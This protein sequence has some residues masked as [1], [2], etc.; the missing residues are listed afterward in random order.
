MNDIRDTMRAHLRAHGHEP[1]EDH[2]LWAIEFCRSGC[3]VAATAAMRVGVDRNMARDVGDALYA[4]YGRAVEEFRAQQNADMMLVLEV[5]RE[6]CQAVTGKGEPDHPI[7]IN[8][9]G[10]LAQLQGFNAPERVNVETKAVV[11][12]AL[13]IVQGIISSTLEPVQ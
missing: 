12:N 10:K 7:R 3:G 1:T 6:G 8:S 13:A 2:V 5:Y 11:P 4:Y 9:A